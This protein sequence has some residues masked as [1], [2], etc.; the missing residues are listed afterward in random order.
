MSHWL[1]GQPS[2]LPRKGLHFRWKRIFFLNRKGSSNF[3]KVPKFT[4]LVLPAVSCWGCDLVIS[5]KCL[6]PKA[7][8]LLLFLL[9]NK[10][11]FYYTHSSSPFPPQE[12]YSANM[13]L[14]VLQLLILF[15]LCAWI[16]GILPAC[17]IHCL[18]ACTVAACASL[19][20]GKVCQLNLAM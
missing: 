10:N 4:E 8:Y 12:S 20:A 11:R 2:Q 5:R 9:A 18:P 17:L 14:T 13:L 16:Y 15:G 1:L 6:L 3:P 19:V 7:T